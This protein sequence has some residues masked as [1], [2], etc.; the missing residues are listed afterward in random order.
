MEMHQDE[1]IAHFKVTKVTNAGV[2]G[3]FEVIGWGEG[4][5][6][7]VASDVVVFTPAN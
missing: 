4:D 7:V 3:L 5:Q 1:G 2:E 6:E